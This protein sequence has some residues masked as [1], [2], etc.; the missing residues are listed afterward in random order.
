MEVGVQLQISAALLQGKNSRYPLNRRSDG[1]Q[2]RPG[3]FAERE[4][5]FVVHTV[6]WLLKE[7]LIYEDNSV[8]S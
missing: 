8:T 2:K 3:L 5:C 6:T 7:S 4:K 1:L